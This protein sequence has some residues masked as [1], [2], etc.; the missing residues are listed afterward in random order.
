MQVMEL[1]AWLR[2][3]QCQNSKLHGLDLERAQKIK[4]KIILDKVEHK[5]S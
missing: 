4:L 1:T 3:E 2:V 5:L